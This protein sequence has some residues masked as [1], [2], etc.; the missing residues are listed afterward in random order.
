MNI[1]YNIFAP[2]FLF[3]NQHDCPIYDDSWIVQGIAYGLCVDSLDLNRG[4]LQQVGRDGF[5]LPFSD[6]WDS[7]YIDF[8]GYLCLCSRNASGTGYFMVR[9]H[10]LCAFS[11]II[12][13]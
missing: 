2:I 13:I 5:L 3:G 7:K 12:C 11:Y 6:D 9:L 10:H 4:S 8:D 1:L